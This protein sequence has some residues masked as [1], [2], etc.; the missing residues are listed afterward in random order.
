MIAVLLEGG[1]NK[2]LGN[3]LTNQNRMQE[4]KLRAVCSRGM[5]A[6]KKCK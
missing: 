1:R 2:I 4:K 5:L 6:I 3:K